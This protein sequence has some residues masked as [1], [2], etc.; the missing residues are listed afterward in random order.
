MASDE[1]DDGKRRT[2]PHSSNG[3]QQQRRLFTIVF[4]LSI[5]V[6]I[7]LLFFF[8]HIRIKIKPSGKLDAE[9]KDDERGHGFEIWEILLTSCVPLFTWRFRWQLSRMLQRCFVAMQQHQQRRKSSMIIIIVATLLCLALIRQILYR[10]SLCNISRGD[11][12]MTTDVGY[13]RTHPH[14]SSL[15]V[16]MRT[17]C[18]GW[19]EPSSNI[20][21]AKGMLLMSEHS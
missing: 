4:M 2:S 16:S 9:Q 10:P 17:L 13:I 14:T 7:S 12:W 1:A 18:D 19:R 8:Y 11:S 15:G 5:T 6:T 21:M 20:F 3:S